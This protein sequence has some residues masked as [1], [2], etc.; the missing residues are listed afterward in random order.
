MS[1]LGAISTVSGTL[2]NMIADRDGRLH[3]V[4]GGTPVIYSTT[5]AVALS[6]STTLGTGYKRPAKLKRIVVTFS[7]APTTSESLTVTIYPYGSG[8]RPNALVLS[9]N[10][11][12][13]SATTIVNTW[14]SGYDLALGDEVT[15]A[16][17][18]TDTRTIKAEIEV[19]IL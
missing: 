9:T 19:E 1:I 2:I 5:T 18:N 6:L 11:S 8:T 17:T 12:T 7:T 16:F 10:P 4:T 3:V 14:D 13:T 15:M